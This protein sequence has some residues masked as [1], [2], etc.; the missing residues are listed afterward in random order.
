MVY[1]TLIKR[2]YNYLRSL[3]DP[4]WE[5]EPWDKLAGDLDFDTYEANYSEDHSYKSHFPTKLKE[6]KGEDI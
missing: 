1:M 5:H 4:A 2:F 6:I 3:W